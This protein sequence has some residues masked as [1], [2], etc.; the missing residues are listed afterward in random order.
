MRLIPE[1]SQPVAY[2]IN[3]CRTE[4]FRTFHKSP[5]AQSISVILLASVM[6]TSQAQVLDEIIVTATKRAENIQDVPLA[7]TAFSGEFLKDVN[8]DDIKDLVSF[9]PGVTGNS[10]DSFI[11]AISIRGIRTQ[12]YGVGGDP[13]AA[14]FKNNLYEGRNGAVV[15]SLYDMERAEVLR[16]PQAFLFGRNAIGGAFNVHTKRPNLDGAR[17]GYI[18]VDVAERGYLTVEGGFT[19]AASDNF[20]LRI[21]GYHSEEDGYVKNI[22]DPGRDLIGHEK[23]AVR[24]SGLYGKDNLEVFFSAD[25]ED[26]DRDGTVYTASELSP[27]LALYQ[28]VLG[29]WQ[30]PADPRNTNQDLS[31]GNFD[32]AKITTLGLHVDYDFDSM[33]LTWS[34]G[35]KDHDYLYIEDYDSTP[36]NVETY[37]Q[38]QTG[39]YFQTELRLLSNTDGPLSWY[40]GVSYY[41]EEIDAIFTDTNDEELFCAYYGYYYGVDNCSDYF[42]Y[43][44][45]YYDTNFPAD[46]IVVGPFVPT[47][48]GMMETV[49]IADGVY[50]GWAAYVDLTYAFNDQ[51]DVSV[52]LRYSYDKKD[53]GLQAPAPASTLGSFYFPGY[54]TAERLSDSNDWDDTSPRVILRYQPSDNTTLFASYT[55]GYKAG[56]FGTFALD[57]DIYMWF[58][59]G[60]GGQAPLT[61]A[62]GYVPGQFKPEHVVS[63]EIGYK[64]SLADGRVSL[65]VTAFLYEFTDL[66]VNYFDSGAKVGNAGNVDGQ[67]IEGSIQIAFTDNLSLVASVGFLDTEARGVQFLCGGAPDANGLLRPNAIDFFNDPPY[68]LDPDACEGNPLYWAPEISGSAVLKGNFPVGNGSIISNLEVFFES[69]RGRGYEDIIDSQIDAFQEWAFR[70][71]YASDNNWT[72]MAYV[73]NFT[74]ELTFDGSANNALIIPAFY[75]GPSRPR[76]MGMRFGYTFD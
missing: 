18:D 5:L 74:N 44:Q 64:G 25:Y 10:K 48:D 28:T 23:T 66:Q 38:D 72:L 76:T 56:G 67:G 58:G 42:D 20:G 37:K 49:T 62:D 34:T 75:F 65:D 45:Y 43:W 41:R 71:G 35:Y 27:R 50:N 19:V 39:N 47:A 60:F 51:W 32:G 3:S 46:G 33:S 29:T 30:S 8:L 53:F 2:G 54:V 14:F 59:D 4:D 36:L 24:I 57:P 1:K 31:G 73:E 9:T 69:E 52:G 40:A 21:A 11:D 55:E 6:G 12:D 16:G 15:S 22:A 68:P 17:D 70:I 13:S 61:V 26:F 7:I 63:Y